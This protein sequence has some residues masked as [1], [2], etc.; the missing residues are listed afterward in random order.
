[1]DGQLKL[2]E[3]SSFRD[4]WGVAV[5]DK[6]GSTTTS[7][8]QVLVRQS[9][10]TG[11][12]VLGDVTNLNDGWILKNCAALKCAGHG[13][14]LDSESKLIDRAIVSKCGDIVDCA[15]HDNASDANKC[16]FCLGDAK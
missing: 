15:F 8:E 14:H 10:T 11:F 13:L 6:V 7:L 5:E 3:C 12:Y 16:R 2:S 9:S 4:G 1:M